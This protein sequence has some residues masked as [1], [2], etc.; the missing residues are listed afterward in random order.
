MTDADGRASTRIELG[1]VAGDLQVRA[2]VSG[3]DPVLFAS[4]TALPAPT[5]QSLSSASAD[6]GDTIDV[7]VSDLDAGLSAL[8]L[9]DGV[10]GEI[11][12]RQDGDPAVLS[13]IVPAP[14][15]TLRG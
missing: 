4:L 13:T 5:I 3:L 7:N 15:V 12:D 14:V 11:V 9:F 8:V 6:P 2:S 10:E 1:G